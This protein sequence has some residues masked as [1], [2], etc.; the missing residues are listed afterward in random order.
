MAFFLQTFGG[1]RLVDLEGN[2][3]AFPEKGLLL[4]AYL[5]HSQSESATRASIARLLWGDDDTLNSFTNLRKLVSRIKARQSEMGAQLFIFDDSEVRL[6]PT[7]VTCDVSVFT[8]EEPGETF[9]KLALIVDRLRS[10]FLDNA[11]CHNSVFAAW[12][13]DRNAGHLAVL[14]EVLRTAYLLPAT[15]DDIVLIKEAALLAFLARPQDESIHRILLR[16]YDAEGEVDHLRTVFE[17]RKDLL[18]SWSVASQGAKS[19]TIPASPRSSNLD[20]LSKISETIDSIVRVPR[21]ALLPPSNHS[22][23]PKAAM[24]ASSLIEDITVGFCA[25]NS[26]QVIAP[27]SAVKISHQSEDQVNTFERYD[28]TYV[29]DTRLSGGPGEDVSLYAHLIYLPNQEI[30]WAERYSLN[31]LDLM[32]QRRD[33]ARRIAL[34]VVG[35]IET[36]EV[37]RSYFEKNAAAYHRYLIGRQYLNRLTLP[38]LRR[39]RK[40]LKGALQDGSDFA[41]ALSSIARTYSKEWLLTA[42]GDVDLLKTAAAYATRAIEARGDFADG[43]REL[44]VANLL[45]GSIDESVQALELSETLSPHY[46]DIIADH[47]DTLVHFSRPDLALQKIER[48][49]ELNPISPDS[50][51][52][53][54][55]GAS[56]CLGDFKGALGHVDQMVDSDLADR[57]SAASWAMLGDDEKARFFVRRTRETNPDFDVDKWLAF[58]PLKE[59]WQRDIYREGLKKAGF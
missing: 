54:A 57:L 49:M 32:R 56:Y 52:W 21:V 15:P 7:M 5:F 16:T 26:L 4:L 6:N 47:A 22:R 23:D 8:R 24:I 41:P 48:A 36:H 25:L 42:R 43:Y 20:V 33:I 17:R 51:L 46:A 55:A 18:L 1:L 45:L 29:F 11:D 9:D 10:P 58:V 39:A 59:Q 19:A 2:G 14:T 12:I 30:V 37:T 13:E 38:N 3:V 35:R 28:I 27:H 53:T 34:A 44:G 50:Y 40:E 31:G